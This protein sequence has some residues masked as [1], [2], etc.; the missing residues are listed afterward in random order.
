MAQSPMAIAEAYYKAMG[1]KNAGAVEKYL[2]P[3][4]QFIAPLAKLTGKENVLEAAKRFTLLF[5]SLKIRCKF[6]SENQ[7]MIVYDLECPEPIGSFS[8]T[9]LMTFHEGL[10]SKIELFYDA[11]P[12]EK[13]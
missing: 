4:I 7:A 8:S 2:H 6:G 12:F 9:S 3:D 1:E 11:R 13:K 10:I 5:K